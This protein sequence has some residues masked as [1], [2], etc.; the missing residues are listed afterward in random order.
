M[1]EVPR[2]SFIP[3]QATTAVSS[4]VRKKRHF[5][6]LGLISS[7]VLLTSLVLAGGAYF[8]KDFALGRLAQ[9]KTR[10]EEQRSLFVQSDMVSVRELD[11]RFRAAEYLLQN[12]I[13]PSKIFDTLEL[14]TKKSVQFTSLSFSRLPSQ[15]VSVSITGATEEFKTVAL[16]ALQFGDNPLLKDAIFGGF[17]VVDDSSG[18]SELEG[19]D[20]PP[21]VNFKV[22]GSINS[23]QLFYDP[24]SEGIDD[25]TQDEVEESP[26][27][28][29][30]TP[31]E[32]DIP[33][34]T[35]DSNE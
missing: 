12:H 24:A 3:K 4:R 2:S 26:P 22:T 31:N 33:E 7:V 29:T 11:R 27:V 14:N 8:Y 30:E 1:A 23:S 5:N 28:A 9:E 35:S 10:L 18:D 20:A 25:I 21:L 17:T 34:S 13:S 16:Q 19:P 6:V 15:T 32:G